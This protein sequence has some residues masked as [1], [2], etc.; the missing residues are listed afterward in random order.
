MQ[1]RN[2]NIFHL[3][4]KPVEGINPHIVHSYLGSGAYTT[5]CRNVQ[6]RWLQGWYQKK[7]KSSIN[8]IALYF[9]GLTES[10]ILHNNMKIVEI[11]STSNYSTSSISVPISIFPW[12][13]KSM[14]VFLYLV[15]KKSLDTA[16]SRLQTSLP[17]FPR[18]HQIFA[19]FIRSL[20][21]NSH[22]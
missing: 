10:T 1:T 3:S 9:Y 21:E 14:M 17:V 12:W 2:G 6:R 4:D 22:Q 5:H 7:L 11:L 15:A 20:K 16:D 13:S 8:S 18:W 19:M